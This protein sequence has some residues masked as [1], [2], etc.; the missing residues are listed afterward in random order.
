[1]KASRAHLLCNW[2]LRHF[3]V[4]RTISGS[5]IRYRARRLESLAL[6]AE[7]FDMHSLYSLNSIPGNIRTF[8]DLGCNVGYFTCWLSHQMK[9]KELKGIIVDA[10]AE[11]IEDA[12]WHV[13]ANDLRNVHPLYGLAGAG[14][15]SGE[16]D[17]FLHV[18]NIVSTAFPRDTKSSM[19]GDWKKVKV[20]FVD[21]EARWKDFFQ[22]EPCDL[23][24]LDIEGS[25]MD[26]FRSE[27]K[28]LERVKAIL[29]EW[30]KW[31]VSLDEVTEYL[32]S[33]GFALKEVLHDETD[34]GTAIFVRP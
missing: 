31:C 9:D 1:M 8:A 26:F 13:K 17:F 2:W 18:S 21:V 14:N 12:Q 33:Q 34:L 19:S 5:T 16:G 28:F 4:E 3:P 7:M 15:K 23:L 25:E 11:A 24:K 30:H 20:P 6:S 29:L 32:R 22:N 10:N 27:T